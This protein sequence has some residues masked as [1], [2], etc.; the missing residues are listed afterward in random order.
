MPLLPKKISNTGISLVYEPEGDAASPVVDIVVVHGLQGHPFTTWACKKPPPSAVAS[1]PPETQKQNAVRQSLRRMLSLSPSG[2]SPPIIPS[3]PP[4]PGVSPPESPAAPLVYWPRDLLPGDCP[5][6]RVL[7]F[8]Y[9]SKVTNYI[10]AATNMNT[11]FSHAKDLLFAL[12][13]A[14]QP[15]RPLIFVAHSLGG[16]V[17]KEMLAQSSVA[18]DADLN[19]IVDSTSAVV[20]LGTPHR[21]SKELA[22][23][24]EWAR[25]FAS[26]RLRMETNNSILG[27]LS[28]RTTDLERAQEAFSALWFKYDFRVKTFQEGLG[29]TGFNFSLLGKKVVPDHSSLIGDPRERAETIQANHMEMCRFSAADDP[30]YLKLAG[31]I[32]MVYASLVALNERQVHRNGRILRGFSLTSGWSP[33]SVTSATSARRGRAAANDRH[34]GL[35]SSEVETLNSL[36]YPGMNKR[37]Q[38]VDEPIAKT[39]L[40]LFE[41]DTYQH[42]L[43]YQ[44]QQEHR[45]LLWLKGKPGSGKSTLMKE[46][47]RRS[48]AMQRPDEF[49]TASFF[50]DAKGSE[51]EHSFTGMLRSVLH[52]LLPRYPDQLCRLAQ[53]LFPSDAP[54]SGEPAELDESQ[55][56]QAFQSLFSAKMEPRAIV[57]IDAL[58]ECDPESMRRQAYFWREMT[59]KAY[60]AGNQLSLCISSR[61][62]PSISVTDCPEIIVDH[63]NNQDIVTYVD[64]RLSLGFPNDAPEW[65]AL[66]DRILERSDGI[67]LWV[68]LVVEDV[69]KKWDDGESLESLLRGL[70][71]VPVELEALFLSLLRDVEPSLRPLTL[72]LF[73]WAVLATRPLRL[74]EWQHILG[75]ANSCPPDTGKPS[76]EAWRRSDRYVGNY[77]QLAK[78]IRKISK[79]LLEMVSITGD[80]ALSSS[81]SS[82]IHPGAGSLELHQ[83]ENRTIQVIHESVR[84]FLLSGGASA[85]LD[86]EIGS[87]FSA[88]G[89]ISIMRT[90]LYYIDIKELDALVEARLARMKNVRRG[91]SWRANS[92]RSSSSSSGRS[93]PGSVRAFASAYSYSVSTSDSMQDDDRDRSEAAVFDD[94][95][96]AS[97]TD[98][99]RDYF[100]LQMSMDRVARELSMDPS[101]PHA[102]TGGR[103]SGQTQVLEDYAA[104]LH[105]AAVEMFTHAKLAQ[106]AG[107]DPTPV[108]NC[109]QGGEYKMWERL[110]AL[111][112][113]HSFGLVYS[114][115][116]Q[117]LV[118]WIEKLAGPTS[119]PPINVNENSFRR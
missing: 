104:L 118:S 51:L 102:S 116:C 72:E 78:R 45:G 60:E 46:A 97:D 55:L 106:Q 109:L 49:W 3:S 54:L 15:D 42:W 21:G 74:Y 13:R 89:H 19:N 86:K 67:F 31:E 105:Y 111:G 24:G 52:Q 44:D 95:K 41:Q 22:T 108:V 84:E 17:V 80:R 77:D 20:F 23:V 61:H 43:G 63:H 56:R 7:V 81:G 68:A 30:N 33:R 107:A 75:F 16:V 99:G 115:A 1:Q 93:S 39:C 50:F 47:L 96:E 100:A 70:D 73:Q 110:L 10:K 58:D 12:S 87:S 76:L 8:G 117:G 9:D 18:T 94:L 90:C 2:S 5:R 82:S 38:A 79:G 25:S 113:G 28:L 34:S 114:A 103:Q 57:F 4:A 37:R 91:R 64:Q 14:R 69:L 36:W 62:F 83:G 27:A 29:L 26:A 112:E 48:E 85:L 35:G 6:S 71:G 98:W 32:R 53:Q 59:R 119:A 66:K 92:L 11:V 65:K 101:V 88:Q 40:W